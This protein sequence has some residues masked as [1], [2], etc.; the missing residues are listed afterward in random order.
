MSCRTCVNILHH[1]KQPTLFSVFFSACLF[2]GFSDSALRLK[3]TFPCCSKTSAQTRRTA[4]RVKRTSKLVCCHQG[5]VLSLFAFLQPIHQRGLIKKGYRVFQHSLF[6]GMSVPDCPS[7]TTSCQPSLKQRPSL[8][9]SFSAPPLSLALYKPENWAWNATHIYEIIYCLVF[10]FHVR[11][12]NIFHSLWVKTC[13]KDKMIFV[14]LLS[15]DL[16]GDVNSRW[17]CFELKH[18]PPIPLEW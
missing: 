1:E 16:Q 10:H 7:A 9:N 17:S 15:S 4:M 5:S 18:F 14:Q 13:E 11:K 2:H 8:S 12:E 3:A 6:P